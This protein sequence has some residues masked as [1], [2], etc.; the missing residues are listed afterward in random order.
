VVSC[1]STGELHERIYA[2]HRVL[3]AAGFTTARHDGDGAFELADQRAVEHPDEVASLLV[4]AGVPP[5]TLRVERDDLETH[6][7]RLISA[8]GSRGR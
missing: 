4:R 5:V 2:P 8:E 3:T 7:L 6:F 1:T